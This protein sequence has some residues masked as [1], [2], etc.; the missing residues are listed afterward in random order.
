V[1]GE[2]PYRWIA[3]AVAR[4]MRVEARSLTMAEATQI[5]GPLAY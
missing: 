4:D 3:E 5:F 2:I 1:A